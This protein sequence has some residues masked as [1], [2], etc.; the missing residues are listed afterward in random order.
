MFRITLFYDQLSALAYSLIVHLFLFPTI[1][2]ILITEPVT[3]I[4]Y[5][6][7]L[8]VFG[9][10]VNMFRSTT[11]RY[12]IFFIIT[13]IC[14]ALLHNH[15]PTLTELLELIATSLLIVSTNY[16]SLFLAELIQPTISIHTIESKNE[17]ITLILWVLGTSFFAGIIQVVLPKIGLVLLLCLI[18]AGIHSIKSSAYTFFYLV[19]TW[20][21]ILYILPY[22]ATHVFL[23]PD[24]IVN[25]MILEPFVLVIKQTIGPIVSTYPPSFI[26]NLVKS[27]TIAVSS[28][29]IYFFSLFVIYQTYIATKHTPTID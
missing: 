10:T 2:S 11:K 22:V 15:Q 20:P 19:S 29:W 23:R 8:L 14:V 3:V 18:Y 27:V 13:F 16:I 24:P 9:I 12:T 28:S 26:I 7:V 25:G 5:I 1:S 4:E 17:E 21:L 6:A